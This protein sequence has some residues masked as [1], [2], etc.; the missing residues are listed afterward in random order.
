M[1]NFIEIQ[2][3]L[4]QTD[5]RTQT[6]IKNTLIYNAVVNVRV[7]TYN[8]NVILQIVTVCI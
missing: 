4:Y 2:L 1:P 6:H 8:S 7:M 3:E 5:R